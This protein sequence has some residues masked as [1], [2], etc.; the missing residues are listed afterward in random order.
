VAQNRLAATDLAR[1]YGRYAAFLYGPRYNQA[2]VC[3]NAPLDDQVSDAVSPLETFEDPYQRLLVGCLATNIALSPGFYEGA[4]EAQSSVHSADRAKLIA[5]VENAARRLVATSNAIE[6]ILVSASGQLGG[7]NLN[8]VVLLDAHLS[9]ANLDGLRLFKAYIDGSA[10]GI[11]LQ[12]ADLRQA[13]LQNFLLTNARLDYANVDCAFFEWVP[14]SKTEHYPSISFR[15]A[16]WWKSIVLV[17]GVSV[18]PWWMQD[19]AAPHD[20]LKQKCPFTWVKPA[21][22]MA[23]LH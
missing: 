19:A 13:T 14:S 4:T 11:S 16:N 2:T 20:F 10:T 8:N 17:H 6:A 12:H 21:S 1:A 15:G 18:Q 23:S 22:Y 5:A 7:A 9:G 3:S